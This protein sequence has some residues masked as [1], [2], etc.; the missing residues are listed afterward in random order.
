MIKMRSINKGYL[1]GEERLPILKD[2]S[3]SVEKGDYVAI[4]M[5]GKIQKRFRWP[6]RTAKTILPPEQTI[7]P[8]RKETYPN[9]VF[10]ISDAG[11]KMD[12]ASASNETL[13]L[14]LVSMAVIVFIVGGIGIMNPT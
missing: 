13:T 3:F 5:Q 1:L 9:T 2:I 11:S 12:A 14:L 4:C 10:A 7:Q 6:H 8:G